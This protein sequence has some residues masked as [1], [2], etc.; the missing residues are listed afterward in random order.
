MTW[1]LKSRNPPADESAGFHPV[2]DAFVKRGGAWRS[3]EKAYVKV[4][5]E[6][7]QFYVNIPSVSTGI[8]ASPSNSGLVT[9]PN[10]AITISGSVTAASGVVPTGSR[11]E[12]RGGATVYASALT[13]STGAYTLSWTPTTAA[14]YALTVRFVANGVY[15]TSQTSVVVRVITGTTTTLAMS[16]SSP[17]CGTPFTATVSVA[18]NTGQPIPGGTI[19]FVH[20]PTDTSKPTTTLGTATVVNGVATASVTVPIGTTVGSC[21]I[22]ARYT[23]PVGPA[24][25]TTST[26]SSPT[27]TLKSAPVS[28]FVASGWNVGPTFWERNHPTVEWTAAP[29]ATTY[30]IVCPQLNLNAVVPGPNRK[31][32]A[33]VVSSGDYQ[34]YVIASNDNNSVNSNTLTYRY[35]YNSVSGANSGQWV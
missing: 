14:N 25:F 12:L 9:A 21:R 24:T 29:N 33:E 31:Y 13:T 11:V 5:G 2:Q 7:R 34:F 27:I 19:T 22:Q 32:T 1:W 16:T 10:T 15:T 6:W 28:S 8:S 26:G 35:T 18:A 3:I 20:V 30:R 17:V 23:E 4:D